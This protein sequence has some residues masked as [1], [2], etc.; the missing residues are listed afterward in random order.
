MKKLTIADLFDR[1]LTMETTISEMVNLVAELNNPQVKQ[2]AKRPR[3]AKESVESTN[4]L[5]ESIVSYLNTTTNMQEAASAKKAPA[6]HLQLLHDEGETVHH[7]HDTPH[8]AGAEGYDKAT[9]TKIYKA[10]GKHLHSQHPEDYSSPA[11]AT[12][13]YKEAHEDQSFHQHIVPSHEHKSSPGSVYHVHHK[14]LDDYAKS[15]AKDS[16]EFVQDQHGE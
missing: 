9:H 15:E 11:D 16:H 14:T 10:I 6:N 4:P 3:I 1:G 12:K 8:P 13:K 2:T 5:I 7:I